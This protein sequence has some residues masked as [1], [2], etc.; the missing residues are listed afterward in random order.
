MILNEAR[1]R[2][3]VKVVDV[4][5]RLGVSVVTVR[6]DIT[7]LVEAGEL[8]RVHG[9][10]T[11]PAAPAAG[12][13]RRPL[14]TVGM[15]LPASRYYYRS[16]VAGAEEAASRAGMRLVLAVSHYDP[17]EEE[18]LVGRMLRAGVDALLVAT[19]E[20]PRDAPP[21][22]LGTVGVPTV[23][24]ERRWDGPEAEY[25]RS[26]HGAGARLAVEHLAAHGHARVGL[27]VRGSTPTSPWLVQGFREA[28]APGGP[29]TAGFDPV[30]LV[31]PADGVADRDRCLS[32]LLDRCAATGTRAVLVHTDDDAVALLGL[33]NDRGL[34][35]PEDLAIVAYD[36]EIAALAPVPLTA[37][38]PPKRDVGRAAVDL[39]VRRLSSSGDP[40]TQQVTLLPRLVARDSV[41]GGR[42]FLFG[43]V[44][45]A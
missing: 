30:D 15:I 43:L 1:L 39:A 11:L 19:A 35:V 17:A 28:T 44:D 8:A 38:A 34:R 2:G 40:A 13:T 42:P 21:G 24:V 31:R 45:P 32:L 37:V 36:D 6:R 22:W 16:V 4:A 26:D 18:R 12:A 33:A 7:A 29:V 25:V 9:G 3:F 41:T 20:P 14:A 27:A 10:A 5:E 23:L